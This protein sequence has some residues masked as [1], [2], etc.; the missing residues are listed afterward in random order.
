M[1]NENEFLLKIEPTV[2][3]EIC[4]EGE[5]LLKITCK[6]KL[7]KDTEYIGAADSLFLLCRTRDDRYEIDG[8]KPL[9]IV[10]S[11]YELV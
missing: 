8:N 10:K 9:K 7:P 11:K 3:I 1:I 6:P 5:V 4:K 2:L